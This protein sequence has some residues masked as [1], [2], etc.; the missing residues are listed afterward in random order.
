LGFKRLDAVDEPEVSDVPSGARIVLLALQSRRPGERPS[1]MPADFALT[2]DTLDAERHLVA[3]RG[4]LDLHTAPELREVLGRAID[5]GRSRIVVDL[6]E[7]SYMDSSGLTALVVAHKRLRKRDGQLVVVN[8]DPSIG[9]T[10]EI[11]GL[12]L[13]FPLVRERSEAF[14][15]LAE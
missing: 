6:T 9:R 14:A 5:E 10:F 8:V 13:L 7:T 2:E 4:D 12:H 1:A 11:T 15:R 3:V